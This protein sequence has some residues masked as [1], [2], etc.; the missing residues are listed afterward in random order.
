MEA[1][2][3]KLQRPYTYHMESL[4]ESIRLEVKT[5]PEAFKKQALWC[6][7]RPG[8]RVLD[9]GCGPGKTT[10]L[11]QEIVQPGGEVLGMDFS[12]KRIAY[13]RKNYG[14]LP[15]IDFQV[16][17]LR[18]SLEVPGKFDLIWVR[19]VLEYNSKESP[20]IVRNLTACLKPDGYLCL[21]DLDHNCLSHWELPPG[22]QEILF[23]IMAELERYY[24]FDVYAG[25]KLYSYLYDLDFR[26]I[27]MNL[28]PHHLIYGKTQES[29]M[30]NWTKKIEVTSARMKH[31]FET[32][33]GGYSTFF[34]NFRLFFNDPRRLTYTPLILCKGIKPLP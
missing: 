26:N 1:S 11:L 2:P 21:M 5:N 10:A 32:Y 7:V 25:R 6:G 27:E 15:G 34:K 17:D 9:A 23:K 28:F 4:E 16:H 12:D 31:L 13:A 22:M 29:D 3:Q 30:F 14:H 20:D 18:D 19:F 8:M 33:P 24:N